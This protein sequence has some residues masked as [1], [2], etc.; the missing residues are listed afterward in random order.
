MAQNER[1]LICD[2]LLKDLGKPRTEVL[3]S[4]VGS[5]IERAVKSA[6]HL[7]EWAKTEHPDVGD[8]QK[9]WNPA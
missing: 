2:A 4:E 7:P 6:E 5:I 9:S 1:E 8:W 3:T